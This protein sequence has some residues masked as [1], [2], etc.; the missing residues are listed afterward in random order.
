MR[1]R[2][3][4]VPANAQGDLQGAVASV[5][6]LSSIVGP[7]LMTEVFG[8][9]SAP[10]ARVHFPGAAFVS[11][12]AANGLLCGIVFKRWRYLRPGSI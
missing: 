7:P 3:A 1:A 4:Q 2:L 11:V 9:F 6:G 10:T 12:S 8:Y 5:Y